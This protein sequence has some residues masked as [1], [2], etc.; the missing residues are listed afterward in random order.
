MKPVLL[1]ILISGS[2]AQDKKCIV[3][4]AAKDHM[5]GVIRGDQDC[6]KD[7]PD[8]EQFEATCNIEGGIGG[9][10]WCYNEIQVNWVG[11]GLQQITVNR[12]CRNINLKDE[13]MEDYSP[14]LERKECHNVCESVA[15]TSACNKDTVMDAMNLF[16]QGNDLSC[17]ECLADDPEDEAALEHCRNNPDSVTDKCPVYANAACFNAK[18]ITTKPQPNQP[19]DYGYYKGCSAF[20]KNFTTCDLYVNGA[21]NNAQTCKSTCDTEYCNSGPV[22]PPTKCYVCDSTWD[23]FGIVGQ[24]DAR[25]IYPNTL[26]TEQLGTCPEEHSYCITG[27]VNINKQ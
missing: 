14:G 23:D 10:L 15:G 3:C 20:A 12:G 25:C 26:S 19:T 1:Y 27:T 21:L 9:E 18:S 22:I 4:N 2:H 7:G 11:A 8:A 13:C 6:F 24:G 16:D 5:G 17:H